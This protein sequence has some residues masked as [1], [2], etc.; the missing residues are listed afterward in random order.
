M[1]QWVEKVKAQAGFKAHREV[2]LPGTNGERRG[3]WETRGLD[4]L[5]QDNWTDSRS[6]RVSACPTGACAVGE[7]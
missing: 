5:E 3:G 6:L 1:I 7:G 4:G 2:R